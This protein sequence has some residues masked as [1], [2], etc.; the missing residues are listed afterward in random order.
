MDFEPNIDKLVKKIY[1]YPMIG[2]VVSVL[3][4]AII[5]IYR[6]QQV[7][8][9]D[10]NGYKNSIVKL[11]KSEIK[12]RIERVVSQIKINQDIINKESKKNV[13]NMVDFA[14]RIIWHIYGKYKNL[15]K[16]EIIEKIKERLE[17]VRFFGNLSGYFFMYSMDGTCLMLPVKPSLEGKNLLNFKDAN[18]VE[19]VRK[20]IGI[21]KKQS[22]SFDS[23]YWYKPGCKKMKKKIGY[24]RR[25]SPLDI[26]IGSAFYEDDVL[27][28]VKKI[29]MDIVQNYRFG[30]KGYIF[31]YDLKGNTISHIKKSLIGTNRIN[32]IINNRHILKEMIQKAKI[33]RN[34]FFIEYTATLDP[35]THKRAKKI[36]FVKLVPSL[37]WIIGTGFYEKDMKRL[38]NSKDSFLKKELDR[39]IIYI[40]II[41]IL[42]ILVLSSVMFYISKRVKQIIYRYKDNLLKQYNESLEQKR[43]F[44]LLFEKSKDG[45]FLAKKG[46]FIDCNEM[47]VSMYGAKDKEELLSKDVFELS[48]EL[49]SNNHTVKS[50]MREL[51]REIETKGIYR[52]E[53]LAKKIDGTPFWIEIVVTEIKMNDEIIFHTICRDITKRKKMENELKKKEVEIS[54]KARHDA[55]T[56]LQNRYAF[57]EIM[58]NEINRIKREMTIFALVFI[59]L[60]GFKDIND[61]YGHDAGDKLLIQVAKRFKKGIRKTDYL[62]RFGGDEFVLILTDCHKEDDVA[63]AVEK[64]EKLFL[65]PFFI[66]KYL[67]KVGISLGITLCPNDGDSVDKLLKNADIAMYKAKEEGKNRYVFYQE[68]MYKRIQKLHKTEESLKRG[69]K[70]GEFVLFYQ[71]QVDIKIDK[72]VGFEA[73]VRWK[74]GDTVVSPGE[75]IEIAERLN[76]INDIGEIVL[77]KAMKF[78]KRL[79]KDGYNI[80][81][82]A[83]NLSDRQLKNEKILKV[84]KELLKKNECDSELLELEVTEGFVMRDIEKSEKLLK[85]FRELGFLVSMDDFGTGYSSLAYLKK[86]PIDTLKIDQ[87]FIKDIPGSKRDEAIVDTIIEL[88]KGLDLCIIAEGVENEEQ[89]RFLLERECSIIQGYYF[90]KPI[91]ESK[92]IEFIE[93]FQRSIDG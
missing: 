63:T 87:S 82:I 29:A 80:G 48:C 6:G 40:V 51:L 39:T 37:G 5:F 38:I 14:Y 57:T 72:I 20:T 12:D 78:A 50:L 28:K 41:S 49:Q 4:T 33:Y 16:K 17:D 59:D 81:R 77:D 89:N 88:G 24:Y 68:N 46:R 22:S 86:L 30:K 34:G 75:F 43:I 84:I 11:K 10:I 27:K 91:E 58:V 9:K 54:Y 8:N 13:K 36:S 79:S 70:N 64:L 18:G 15:P 83:V 73:L 2:I 93:N 3:L 31:A 65:K 56:G 90:S 42:L 66:D 25:F 32:L 26:F 19:I 7:Y 74:R 44:K 52:G 69:I 21:L 67:I 1:F 45:I 62:F 71:P 92:V 61:Y 76:L 60:D 47:A 85:E 53:W 23:W 55:L 35:K